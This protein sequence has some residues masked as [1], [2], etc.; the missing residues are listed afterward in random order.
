MDDVPKHMSRPERHQVEE[1]AQRQGPR[2][3][4]ELEVFD[5]HLKLATEIILIRRQRGLTQ[6]QLSTKS[7]V[8]QATAR[9]ITTGPP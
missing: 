2:A 5:A 7:G 3:V 8:Q 6:R 1:E 4:A 9:R